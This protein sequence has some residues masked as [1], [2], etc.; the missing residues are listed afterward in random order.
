MP[1]SDVTHVIFL[2]S[3]CTLQEDVLTVTLVYL[4]FLYVKHHENLIFLLY[5]ANACFDLPTHLDNFT[6]VIYA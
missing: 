1:F 3:L 6:V 4:K 2:L 5:A